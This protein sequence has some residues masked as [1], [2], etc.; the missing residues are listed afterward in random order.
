MSTRHQRNS[1]HFHTNI[2]DKRNVAFLLFFSLCMNGHTNSFWQVV[3]KFLCVLMGSLRGLVL[4]SPLKMLLANFILL[5]AASCG[6][7]TESPNHSDPMGQE[8]LSPQTS[9]AGLQ[10]LFFVCVCV[11]VCLHMNTWRN[12]SREQGVGEREKLGQRDKRKKKVFLFSTRKC[13]NAFFQSYLG[14][15]LQY[16]E[17]LK[18]T[19]CKSMWMQTFLAMQAQFLC[20]VQFII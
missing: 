4:T 13:E 16:D 8:T 15:F 20:V 7:I 3:P 18:W 5:C 6:W 12:E 10:E 14:L 19:L 1:S 17:D 9:P 11:C 2:W